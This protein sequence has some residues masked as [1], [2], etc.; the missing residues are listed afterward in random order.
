MEPP[1][2]LSLSH[3]LEGGCDEGSSGPTLEVV[4]Q[5]TERAW[6]ATT[7]L[8]TIPALDHLYLA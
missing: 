2:N 8:P 4:E 5:K 6:A 1:P 7:M 3:W